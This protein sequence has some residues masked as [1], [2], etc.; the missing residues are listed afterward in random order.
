[1]LLTN[2]KLLHRRHHIERKRN[3]ILV[4]LESEPPREVLP[5]DYGGDEGG[6]EGAEED[7]EGDLAHC[8]W[9][10]GGERQIRFEE[11][12]EV[13]RYAGKVLR[14]EEAESA[15]ALADAVL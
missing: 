7:E 10:C 8:I 4:L 15:G 2:D 14:V 6:G 12:R 1:M 5:K 13:R 9:D 3:I 11:W